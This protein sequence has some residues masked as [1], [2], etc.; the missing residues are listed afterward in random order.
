[1]LLLPWLG[2]LPGLHLLESLLALQC[3]QLEERTWTIAGVPMAVCSRCA[4]IYA[5]VALGASFAWPRLSVRRTILVSLAALVLLVIESALE[6][7]GVLPIFHTLRTLTG[8]ALAWPIAAA[9]A[10][11]L[12]PFR[13]RVPCC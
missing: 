2:E 6:A 5:G 10:G 3:H 7:W 4:G 9:A 1:M 8:L 12:P 11:L 13:V